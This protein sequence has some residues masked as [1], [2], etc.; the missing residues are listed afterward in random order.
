MQQI[1]VARSR[2]AQCDFVVM[3][4]QQSASIVSRRLLGND[5]SPRTLMTARVPLRDG[6]V[7]CWRWTSW[8]VTSGSTD[9]WATAV[10]L[11]ATTSKRLWPHNRSINLAFTPQNT[12]PPTSKQNCNHG[13]NTPTFLLPPYPK[14]AF[15]I[16]EPGQPRCRYQNKLLYVN[17]NSA[18]WSIWFET[19][20]MNCSTIKSWARR[21]HRIRIA[22]ACTLKASLQCI[23][24]LLK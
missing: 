17:S 11:T 23:T 19:K 14:Y 10:A 8:I 6:D 4:Q 2:L 12:P 9:W 20:T 15:C 5:A 1:Q 21:D 22:A 16:F 13:Q 7:V 18:R 3:R 24:L